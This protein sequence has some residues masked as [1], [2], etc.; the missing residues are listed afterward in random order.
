MG[1]PAGTVTFL[2][3]DIEGSAALWEQD[4]AAMRAAL[5]RHEDLLRSAVGAHGGT[6]FKTVGDGVCAAFGGAPEAVGAALAGQVSLLAE[7]WATG[8]PLRVR[9]ALHSGVAEARA[10]DYFGRPLNR[11]SRMVGAGHGA[12]VLLSQATRELVQDALPVG[13]SL[14]DLGVHRLKDLERP[15]RIYQLLHASLPAEFPSLR[16]LEAHPNNL[17]LQLTSY[18]GRQR[19]TEAVKRLLASA[20]LLTLTGSGGCGKTRLAVQAAAEVVEEFPDGV[21]LVELASLTDAALVPLACAGVLR[22]REQAGTTA[23]RVLQESLKDKRLLLILDNCEHVLAA[24]ATLAESLLRTCPGVRVLATTREAMGVAGEQT[25]RVPSLSVPEPEADASVE[26]LAAFDSVHLFVDRAGLVQPEFTLGAHNAGAVAQ[27][28]R[29]LDGIPLALELAAARVKA[30]SVPAIAERLNDRFRLLTG[31][32]RTA[33]TRQQTLR[34][35]ID[36]SYDL[37]SA[38]ERTLLRRLAVFSGG[39]TLEAAERVCPGEGLG[40]GDVL[41][42]LAHLV[43]KSLVIYEEPEGSARYRLLETVR[44]YASERLRQ[45]G[46]GPALRRA[47]LDYYLELA[48]Q[49]EPALSGADQP[50]WLARL[51]LEH[52]NLRAALEASGSPGLDPEVRVRL[53]TALHRFWYVRGHLREGRDWLESALA[54][55]PDAADTLQAKAYNAA[56]IFAWLHGDRRAARSWYERSLALWK[57]AGDRSRAAGVLSN[58]GLLADEEGDAASARGAHGSAL[59]IYRDLGDTAGAARARLNLGVLEIQESNYEEAR[60]LF[61]ECLGV[62]LRLNDD[63]RVAVTLQNLGEVASR[64]GRDDAALDLVRQSFFKRRALGD[65]PG[66]AR[67]VLKLGLV[68]RRLQRHEAAAT[69]LGLSETLRAP[70]GAP[71]PAAEVPEYDRAIVDLR[72]RLGGQGFEAAWSAGAHAPDPGAMIETIVRGAAPG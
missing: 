8:S 60:R 32:S 68:A 51:H 48:E 15:E 72:Q 21:W 36:W 47:H 33:P 3:T 42:V 40:E 19:E 28:C 61:E 64:Q 70:T 13:A 17:P 14:K 25:Y 2:F 57:Q 56:G 39:W 71:I 27:V 5:G 6:I 20:R 24:C 11:V 63:H 41:D 45:A 46:D 69:L 50:T 52:D 1:L 35:M 4:G 62:F 67:S 43:D 49:A 34:A 9:M 16:T 54:R 53:T 26:R 59:E 22:V 10:G 44:Q 55:R 58:L 65:Q 38:P 12:Q 37:L 7:P 30:M 23:A 31:G 66:M 29:R 18:V